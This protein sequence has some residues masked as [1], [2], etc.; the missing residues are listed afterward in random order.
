MIDTQISRFYSNAD[1]TFEI[2]VKREKQKEMG[3]PH[4][5]IDP[6][7][8]VGKPVIEGTRITVEFI[9]EELDAGRTL[10]ELQEQYD[11]TLP[12]IHAALD[13]ALDAV[14]MRAAERASA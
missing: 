7:I 9:L 5:I 4:I 6:E 10:A 1:G 13:Y 8:M 3:K 14:R 11:L 12:E 2:S